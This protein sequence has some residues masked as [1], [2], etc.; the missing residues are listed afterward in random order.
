MTG[1]AREYLLQFS[2]GFLPPKRLCVPRFAI[3]SLIALSLCACS[4]SDAALG[5]DRNNESPPSGAARSTGVTRVDL[6][7]LGGAS[8]YATDINSDNTVVGW[9]ETQA[10]ATHAFRWSASGGMRDLGTLP[11]DASSRAVAILDGGQILGASGDDGQWT[12]VV[13]SASGSISALPIPLISGFQTALPSSFNARGDVVG[14]DAGGVA[15]QHG[16]IWSDAGGKYNLSANVPGGSDEGFAG[17]VTSSGTV[18]FT[19]KAFTCTQQCWRTYLW[20][21]TSGF[22]SLGTPGNDPEANVHGLAINASGTVAGWVTTSTTNG[23]VPY[24]WGAGTGF[25][26]LARY[27]ADSYGYA[28]AVSPNGTVVGAALEPTSGS[29]VASAWLIDGS[30]LRL[31]PADPNSSV[32][33]AI[34]SPGTIAGWAAVSNGAN[35]AVIW[36]A[37]SLSSRT[38]LAPTTTVTARVSTASSHCLAD[39]RSITSRQSLF[40][41]VIKA[42]HKR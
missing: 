16:W 14:S 15:V 7:T 8:S 23:E 41:C 25:T 40:A 6:G 4:A 22:T 5:V 38:L 18:V 9:S 19:N 33:V 2:V 3:S 31:S 37:S 30:L 11:G 29:V 1:R 12:P 42:D 34:N 39:A 17:A 32:A 26:L 36:Q 27:S 24:R 10:G 21:Q 35:H 28:T 20:S 13:W